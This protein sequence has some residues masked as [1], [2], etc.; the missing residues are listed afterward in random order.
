MQRCNKYP[1]LRVRRCSAHCALPP[2]IVESGA[3]E[4]ESDG[5]L[6]ER[7]RRALH[8]AKVCIHNG[9]VKEKSVTVDDNLPR[10]ISY[11]RERDSI[12]RNRTSQ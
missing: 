1:T 8:P 2:R 7:W 12:D 3:A 4:F 5:I 9:L 10:L 11:Y 6:I